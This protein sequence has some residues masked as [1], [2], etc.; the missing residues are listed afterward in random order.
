FVAARDEHCRHP[1]CMAPTYRSEIDHTV[2][3]ALGGPTATDNLAHLCLMHHIL[4]GE[5]DWTVI[6]RDGGVLEWTSPTGRKYVERPPDLLPELRS[7]RDYAEAAEPAARQGQRRA[8][9][10]ARS[11]VRFEAADDAQ[12]GSPEDQHPF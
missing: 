3:A 9:P 2:D 8:N 11:R 12:A 5:S 4:K 10:A 7:A 1:G 6:Q